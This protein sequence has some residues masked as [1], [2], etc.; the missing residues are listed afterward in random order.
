MKY[1]VWLKV[2]VNIKLMLLESMGMTGEITLITLNKTGNV[3]RKNGTLLI[4]SSSTVTSPM[5]QR[6]WLL[7][8]SYDAAQ[9][10]K[11]MWRAKV[12]HHP[13]FFFFFCILIIDSYVSKTIISQKKITACIKLYFPIPCFWS[14]YGKMWSICK[15]LLLWTMGFMFGKIFFFRRVIRESDSRNFVC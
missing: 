5:C 6:C 15:K 11:G 3:I 1:S 10:G 4:W 14:I 7:R 12:E 13:E 8:S 2:L 9:Y